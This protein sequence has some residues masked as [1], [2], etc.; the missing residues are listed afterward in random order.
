MA[1]NSDNLG[2]LVVNITGDFS[3]LQDAIDDAVSTAQDG[4]DQISEALS[5]ISD[6]ST[7]VA[8]D[9]TSSLDEISTAAADTGSALD[10]TA[11][12]AEGLG[13]ALE[14]ITDSSALSDIS[15]EAA[16]ASSEMEDAAAS[17]GDFVDALD[18]VG[19]EATDAA[20]AIDD[21]SG[22]DSASAFDDIA[23][24]A[25]DASG[26]L[27]DLASEA[28]DAGDT[29]DSVSGDADGASA[30]IEHVGES[31]EESEEGLE[32][33]AEQLLAVG[34]ALA[35]TEALSEFV[36]EAV[37]V[38][39]ATQQVQT[40]FQLMGQS[41]EEAETTLEPLMDMSIELAVPFGQLEQSARSLAVSLQGV[42]GVDINETLEAAA[43]AAALTGR[44]FDTVTAA[45]QRVEVTGAVTSRQLLALGLTWQQLAT[46]M[47][48]DVATAQ[49]TLAKGGQDATADLEAVVNA[50]NSIS[51]GAAQAQAQTVLGQITILKNQVDL[52]F[53][54]IGQD[55]A[56]VVTVVV[57][58]ISAM[59]SVARD[60]AIAFQSLPP[61]IQNTVV[62]LGLVAAA[63]VPLTAAVGA[64]GLALS[65]I[66]ALLPSF[67]ALMQSLGVISHE[68]A[69]AETEAAEA[70]AAHGLAASTAA[71][72]IG[73]L[74]V[75]EEANATAA[76][77]S[78]GQMGLFASEATAGGAQLTL[79]GEDALTAAG[80]A[81][82]FGVEAATAGAALSSWTVIVPLAAAGL[83]ALVGG[84]TE[85]GQAA[86]GLGQT[87]SELKEQIGNLGGV[88]TVLAAG[89]TEITSAAGVSQ[90][91]ISELASTFSAFGV[92]V[93]SLLSGV[94]SDLK[95]E[96][97]FNMPAA[98]NFTN[99]A[100]KLLGQNMGLLPTAEMEEQLKEAFE[101]VSALT[102][103]L[104]SL[105]A[106]TQAVASSQ[107]KLETAVN[108]AKASIVELTA[109]EQLGITTLANGVP[110]TD[111]LAAA[112][113]TLT[114]AQNALNKS[115]GDS[116]A[117]I[118]PAIDSI[119]AL[120]QADADAQTKFDN[121]NSAWANLMTAFNNGESTLNG[122]A[123]SSVNLNA[124]WNNLAAAYL[125]ATG[126]VLAWNEAAGNTAGIV[127]AQVNQLTNLQ[128]AV[129]Q[130][131]AALKAQQDAYNAAVA[132]GTNTDQMLQQLQIAFLNNQKAVEAFDKATD[133]SAYS[134]QDLTGV[135]QDLGNQIIVNGKAVTV[136]A[137][138][139]D[140]MVLSSTAA[141]NGLSADT[142][143]LNANSTAQAGNTV[144]VIGGTNAITSNTSAKHGAQDAS[145][146]LANILANENSAWASGHI[147]IQQVSGDLITLEGNANDAGGATAG[148]LDEVKQMAPDMQSAG[149]ATNEEADALLALASAADQAAD[150]V[151]SLN[152]AN[153]KS[154]KGGSGGGSGGSLDAYLE[155]AIDIAQ[156]PG[157]FGGGF[158]TGSDIMKMSQELA[159]ATG[160]TVTD[161]EGQFMPAVTAAASSTNTNTTATT[162]NTTATSANTTATTAST[163]AT[164]ATTTV[165]TAAQTAFVGA[166]NA[167]DTIVTAFASL[168]PTLQ[169][170]LTS[171]NGTL[172]AY[173]D[174]T[175]AL[176]YTTTA[177][178]GLTT[179]I[180]A[181]TAANEL[182]TASATD[183]STAMSAVSDSTTTLA[184][185]Q[186][187]LNTA[188]SNL[189]DVMASTGET[190]GSVVPIFSA[191]GQAQN[192]V[193]VALQQLQAAMETGMT[194]ATED[195]AEA[196]NSLTSAATSATAALNS[197]AQQTS[198]FGNTLTSNAPGTTL[199]PAQINA[200][201][202]AEGT[203]SSSALGAVPGTPG[204]PLSGP[205]GT[206]VPGAAQAGTLYGSYVNPNP[207]L[208]SSMAP[209]TGTGVILNVQVS[210]NFAASDQSIQMLA[211]KVGSAAITNLRTYAGLKL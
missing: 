95:N 190:V 196:L 157:T 179:T 59:V 203:T 160:Q 28:A 2:D 126:S 202:G 5:G 115:W 145:T 89:F 155:D 53:D 67:N 192:Q 201:I 45:L 176:Q 35:V 133:T 125:K 148:L 40:S 57:G 79:F 42:E 76:A 84:I 39:G 61:D 131:N 55:I 114:S 58:G 33:M 154:G 94:W 48:T 13:S 70:T 165:L 90:S 172:V 93:S 32:G 105:S 208:E 151:D 97:A 111:A 207:G 138:E 153:A 171:V 162:E 43:N 174:T 211:N 21:I 50:I 96:M 22:E 210:G 144:T 128:N 134:M 209:S 24:S 143:A 121:A 149:E 47:G 98:I 82:Y 7:Q 81:T 123:V 177:A 88:S 60:L 54:A 113:Q 183:A 68:E 29:V 109:M 124:A 103:A 30:G 12:N 101:S 142:A 46:S 120:A 184:E 80:G 27:S 200:L 87:F 140:G 146:Q 78:A 31:A 17:T 205:T 75:A 136:A 188:S 44:S 193:N 178:D 9:T 181:A 152:S 38:Y 169:N 6:A 159:N 99:A 65:G 166:A 91:S 1:D 4:A 150:A 72:E 163:T 195:S 147:A 191:A 10:E 41:A 66:N 187:N 156:T 23:S 189:N 206:F 141:A 36:T 85:T 129:T 198:Y 107:Q 130:T 110:V 18:D 74:S 56:P 15:S 168:P 173:D 19:N 25:Q 16:G 106:G 137:Q 118:K 132:A 119:Q 37:E 92:D 199:T 117:A 8:S 73:A 194:P 63:A 186:A 182:E 71:E 197:T 135:A 102:P 175:G 167:T 11:S 161:M 26:A 34:E 62:V 49:T 20:S 51:A 83:V 77:T 64:F 69:T 14:G 204:D 3:E 122:L 170:F 180:N 112:Q 164:V 104:S 108:A 158:V 139:L 52:L 185:A 100:L 116:A 86:S 127:Q